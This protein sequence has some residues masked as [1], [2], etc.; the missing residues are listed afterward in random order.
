MLMAVGDFLH[1]GGFNRFICFGFQ[2]GGKNE[3]LDIANMFQKKKKLP[4]FYE[5]F[6]FNHLTR[7]LRS[8]YICC[9]RT[10]RRISSFAL[11]V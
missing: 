7:L 1:D 3:F 10:C 6:F 5:C 4:R 9:E 11:R 2:E 8:P